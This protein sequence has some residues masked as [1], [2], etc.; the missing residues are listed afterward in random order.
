M[1]N[2]RRSL[3]VTAAQVD[4]YSAPSRYRSHADQNSNTL[5]SVVAG[6]ACGAPDYTGQVCRYMGYHGDKLD[7]PTTE[8]SR[9][10][11]NFSGEWKILRST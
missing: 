3:Q 4:P 5:K 8:A 10:A 2:I 6:S 11:H 1:V 7:M 9:P